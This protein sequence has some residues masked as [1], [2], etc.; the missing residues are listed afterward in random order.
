[1]RILI[2][3]SGLS[4]CVIANL[5]S[6][7]YGA[8]VDIIEKRDHI[9]GNCYDY[10]DEN[11][12]L[13]NKYG[14]HIFHTN[15]EIVYNYIKKFGEWI[16]YEHKV[17]G[18]VDKCYVPI[19]VNIE[20]VNKLVDK[21]VKSEKDM[22]YWLKQNQIRLKRDAINGKEAALER[23]GEVLYEK[24]FKHYT[25]KQWNKY[26]EELDAS[27]TKR[28]PVRNNFEDRYF[29]DKYQLYPLNGYSKWFEKLLDDDNI[30]VFL[31]TDWEPND[32]DI[33]KYDKIYYS[34]PIDVFY[35]NRNMKKLEYRSIKFT[36]SSIK[37]QNYYQPSSVV[38]Y[39]GKEYNFTRIVEY[40]HFLNPKCKN[41]TIVSEQ[42]CDEGEPYYPVPNKENQDLYE[43][44]RKLTL[45][46]HNIVFVGRLANYKYFN[47]D[48]AILNAIHIF[49]NNTKFKIKVEEK[50]FSKNELI[51]NKLYREILKRD[52]DDEG[53]R[54]YSNYLVSNTEENLYKILLNSEEKQNIDII[55][56]DHQELIQKNDIFSKTIP[57]VSFKNSNDIL[58]YI[59]DNYETFDIVCFSKNSKKITD[60]ETI[61]GNYY[62]NF[63]KLNCE[64]IFNDGM[65]ELDLNK[66][67]VT[68]EHI[69]RKPKQYYEYLKLNL[70]KG[71]YHIFSNVNTD[72]SFVVARYN[73]DISWTK[74]FNNVTIYNKGSNLNNNNVINILN[75]GREG[76]TYLHHIVNSYK[77]LDDYII[78]CQGCPFEH[79]PEFIDCIKKYSH[80][81]NNT[82]PLTWRWKECDNNCSWMS[83]I[84]STGIPPT[85]IRDMTRWLHIGTNKIHMELL[86]KNFNC[87]FPEKWIDG[88]FNGF[89]IPRLKER[90]NLKENES[91]IAWVFKKLDIKKT[92][93]NYFA[94]FFAANF[95]VSKFNILK[96]PI[97]FYLKLWD[98]LEEHEDHGYILERLWFLIFEYI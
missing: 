83:D 22:D 39:P 84:N 8:K 88:G 19:P 40:K 94:F 91:I 93:P 23:V 67:V 60:H 32:E 73:E 11:G 89:L 97:E 43:E 62:G 25:K 98:F 37:N 13:V 30:K 59:L 82:Q 92:P 90:N 4:G 6:E 96:H 34:G 86:D 36:K 46:E 1:M 95:G 74:L 2:I 41:T 26:P 12:I 9:G 27:V 71:I 76:G 63:V 87:V 80:L 49:E 18:Y 64:Y 20:T 54:I 78:F 10:V 68:D 57:I 44:Y 45:E 69:K 3:G 79:A 66:F 51:V 14:A 17:V 42:S 47:M 24:I 55:Q 61:Y 31:N 58:T 15:S 81:F 52:A 21:N 35:K 16:H 53:L 28:I 5:Y 70:P 56:Q 50:L 7:T 72:V 65:F 85:E 38:N 29:T 77:N 33:K 48:E 75:K